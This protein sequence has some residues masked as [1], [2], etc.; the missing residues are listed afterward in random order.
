MTTPEKPDSSHKPSVD[1]EV[2]PVIE[3]RVRVDKV[4]REGRTVTVRTRPVTETIALSEAVT[5]ENVSIERVPVGK[6]VTE[7][8]PVREEADVTVIPVVEERVRLVVDLVLREEIHLRRTREQ[9]VEEF[10]AERRT[11][12]IDIDEGAQPERDGRNG[13]V[14]DQT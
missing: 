1:E 14:A 12:E 11:T 2:I 10:E 8:P 7:V 9:V 3:E 6:V 13:K 4:P 5:R